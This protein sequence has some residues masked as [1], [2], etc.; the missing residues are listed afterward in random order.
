MLQ[1]YPYSSM[2]Y[3]NVFSYKCNIKSVAPS[4][5]VQVPGN[6]AWE[7]ISYFSR[8]LKSLF[9]GR[10]W[11]FLR[12]IFEKI[13][14][15]HNRQND[16]LLVEYEDIMNNCSDCMDG[17]LQSFFYVLNLLFWCIVFKVTRM[18]QP[19]LGELI[20]TVALPKLLRQFRCQS[21]IFADCKSDR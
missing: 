13:R 9:L 20:R 16:D 7:Q 11:A 6:A 19:D 21:G 1:N 8:F 12:K 14:S 4:L 10:K 5:V 17:G 15:Y 2:S 3:I 18:C